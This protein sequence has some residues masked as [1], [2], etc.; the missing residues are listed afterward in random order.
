MCKWCFL[1]HLSSFQCSKTCGNGLKTRPVNCHGLNSQCDVKIKPATRAPCNLG[2]CAEWTVGD[3][4]QVLLFAEC[5]SPFFL[6][7][8]VAR[9]SKMWCDVLF[10]VQLHV[11]EDG[12]AALWNV[13]QEDYDAITELNLTCTTCVT[14]ESVLC[15]KLGGGV[16]WVSIAPDLLEP[17]NFLQC[18][19]YIS[20]T[21]WSRNAAEAKAVACHHFSLLFPFPLERPQ[22]R[23]SPM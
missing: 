12:D 3:W 2:P 15:G 4:Q 10:S 21:R 11:A 19:S 9:N 1:S 18:H 14:W 22:L 17:I 6:Q 23:V 8:S 5:Q 7:F 20:K 16:R 13:L